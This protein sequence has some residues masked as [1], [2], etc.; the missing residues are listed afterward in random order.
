ML[1]RTYDNDDVDDF[2]PH[3]DRQSTRSK[4]L[5][6]DADLHRAMEESKRAAERRRATEEAE[7]Q[8]AL[9]L[10]EEEEARRAKAVADS[11]AS[12]LFNDA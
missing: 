3:T 9:K 8:K 5:N 11:N 6:E 12:S 10:S 1:G 7:L 2:E 4:S